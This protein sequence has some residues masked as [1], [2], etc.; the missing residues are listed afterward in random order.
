MPNYTEIMREFNKLIKKAGKAQQPEEAKPYIKQA[1]EHL[2]QHKG[3]FPIE[4]S[5]HSY[6]CR[7]LLDTERNLKEFPMS[8]HVMRAETLQKRGREDEA[9]EHYEI[10]WEIAQAEYEDSGDQSLVLK[11]NRLEKKINELKGRE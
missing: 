1:R 11:I 2:E 4:H 3:L 7:A 5:R 6:I 9:M 10:A 8:Y